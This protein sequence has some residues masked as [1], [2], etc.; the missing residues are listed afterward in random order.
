MNEFTRDI[1]KTSNGKYVLVDTAWVS[2]FDCWETMVFKCREN[3]SVTSWMELDVKRYK[4]KDLA[5]R[6]HNEM[7]AKWIRK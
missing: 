5:M 6:G 7:I 2:D 1:V 3:G 4:T